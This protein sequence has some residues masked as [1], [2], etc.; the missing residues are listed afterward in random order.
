MSPFADSLGVP[1]RMDR[2]ESSDCRQAVTG[3]R[4]TP[5][6]AYSDSFR[7]EISLR[8]R[9]RPDAVDASSKRWQARQTA[10]ARPPP[11]PERPGWTVPDVG[12]RT[13]SRHDCRVLGVGEAR[14][15]SSKI[16]ADYRSGRAA[17][18]PGSDSSRAPNS[19]YEVAALRPTPDVSLT[20]PARSRYRVEMRGGPPRSYQPIFFAVA[21]AFSFSGARTAR[22]AK[23]VGAF[24]P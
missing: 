16:A 1:V 24:G 5:P 14:R 11:R 18:T 23:L 10:S 21:S 12:F 13:A 6:R 20:P 4:A 9:V 17:A 8:R 22:Q 3:G 19:A 2:T 7:P 15:G